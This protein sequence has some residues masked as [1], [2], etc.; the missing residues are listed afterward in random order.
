[1]AS[2]RKQRIAYNEGAFRQLNESLERDVHRGR[3]QSEYAGFVCECG[4][5]DCDDVIRVDLET[6]ESI[7]ADAQLFF[8]VRGHEVLDAEDVVDGNDRYVVVR[9]HDDVADIAERTNPRS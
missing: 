6:Y 7:R 5:P 8:A 4:D 1:M 9:K 3:T 2:Q